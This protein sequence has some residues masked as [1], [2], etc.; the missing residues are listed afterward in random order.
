MAANDD[1]KLSLRVEFESAK[2][3][4]SLK[5]LE[6]AFDSTL[7]RLGKSD[8]EIG[9]L[10]AIARDVEAGKTKLAELPAEQQR[11]VRAMQETAR[12]V[13][14]L[15]ELGIARSHKQIRAEIDGLRASYEQLKRTGVLTSAEL[16]QAKGRLND[17][18]RELR[19][20]MNSSRTV[21]ERLGG[22]FGN[23]GALIAGGALARGLA[24]VSRLADSLSQLEGRLRL[25]EG[26]QQAANERLAQLAAVANRAR[27]P[28]A[29]VA[30]AYAKMAGSIRAAGG[31]TQQAVEFNEA[32]AL[33]LKTSGASAQEAGAVMRQL[34]QALQRGRLQGDE[35]V[36]VAENG[37][38]VL[39]Y[40]AA[41]LGVS[42]GRLTEMAQ[43]GELTTDKLLRLTGSLGQIRQDAAQLPTTVG[44]AIVRVQNAF[45]A[46][47]QSSALVRGAVQTLATALTA[48]AAN[49]DV[50]A[51]ATLALGTAFLAVKLP[52]MVAAVT[53]LGAAIAALN[54]VT[55]ALA[56]AATAAVG[57]IGLL[58]GALGGG[59]SDAVQLAQG[60][61]QVKASLGQLAGPVATVMQSLS[62]EVASASQTATQVATRLLEGSA[63][64]AQRFVGEAREQVA[65]IERDAEAARAVIE[66]RY[67]N[68]TAKSQALAAL[69]RTT[70]EQ[71]LA[72]VES[73]QL[74]ALAAVESAY[75]KVREQ[76]G[77]T[78]LDI[79]KIEGET[80]KK[81]AEIWSGLA[82][83]YAGAIARM[84][85][86]NGRL[87]QDI[88]RLEQA[89]VRFNAEAEAGILEERRRSM[90]A[91]AAYADRVR[92]IDAKL[93]EARQAA[94]DGDAKKAEAI[95]RE[96]IRL[97]RSINQ[98]VESEIDGVRT[99][100]ISAAD[101]QARAIR[102]IE[103]A[104]S[105]VNDAFA[106]GKNRAAEQIKENEAAIR[107][108]EERLREARTQA[109]QLRAE[110]EAEFKSRIELDT[111]TFDAAVER[112]N[113]GLEALKSGASVQLKLDEAQAAL[114][115]FKTDPNNTL[116][117]V[118]AA[119]ALDQAG[120]ALA[121]LRR[122]AEKERVP[123]PAGLDLAQAYQDFESLRR[124]LR[125]AETKSRHKVDAKTSVDLARAE[126]LGLNGTDTQS[127]HTITVRRV[128]ANAAG[129]LVGRALAATQT[130]GAAV[131]HFAHGGPV[132]ARM[133][134][135]W[136]PGT[137]N[138]DTVPR[139]LD[140]G[141]FVLRR[142]AVA[143]YRGLLGAVARFAMGG[144]VRSPFVRP[145]PGLPAQGSGG[146]RRLPQRALPEAWTRR[147]EGRRF[148][149][150]DTSGADT[151]G[152]IEGMI[153]AARRAPPAQ[154][155]GRLE[156]A[157]RLAV[158][159]MIERLRALRR[160]G[161]AV[162][163]SAE[164]DSERDA[165]ER[166][167]SRRLADD[168]E[169]AISGI[170][171]TAAVGKRFARGG[172]VPGPTDTVPALLTPGE[173]VV[174]RRT[175]ERLGVGFFESLNA[176]ALPARGLARA[177]AAGVQGFAQGGLV[178]GVVRP[179]ERPYLVPGPLA[180]PASPAVTNAL[181]IHAGGLS[182]PRALARLLLP[183]L[184]ALMRRR[185]A[186]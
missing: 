66:R 46:W 112:V 162:D 102:K 115:A 165:V 158:A 88:A 22:A 134:G 98:A 156:A 97:S 59:A 30:D 114:D 3:E 70:E 17:R 16:A 39:D 103:A 168:F 171:A 93:S 136:V 142:A 43:A 41:S 124:T 125:E 33:A 56:A 9:A 106:E 183:E 132:F 145:G 167:N 6:A 101:A 173:Y 85:S 18:L 62:Q 45:T 110:L 121:E 141:A 48:V 161:V 105:I 111:T 73:A 60:I 52:A 49:M 164:Y 87:E 127:T 94:L 175:V 76:A 34:G 99:T 185:A 184:E 182:D 86:D 42:R 118:K 65:A 8:A 147:G 12:G 26:S 144:R 83:A 7:R 89:R 2:A 20:S 166:F 5:R 131:R 38:R 157:L 63:Q 90:G 152:G 4:T 126:I 14:L 53:G 96:V 176:L 169:G 36:S 69:V 108:L 54:P 74:K 25:V 27:V 77:A 24:S 13:R 15:D 95:G 174:P 154:R 181:T 160:A 79:E 113:R 84:L 138:A 109:E 72:A 137:G 122:R 178:P 100:V 61:E 75:A 78:A 155:W 23:L 130:V 104:Q 58:R 148:F 170:L 92:E 51:G 50:V 150:V 180:Q 151:A 32:L 179:P 135:G 28:V 68:E 44:D 29:D 163:P 128:E 67:D 143:R 123:I 55:L 37:G 80:A 177:L 64:A 11:I 81:R 91:V 47:V 119:L 21:A 133:R 129:G 117:E 107:P 153:E 159:M 1:L 116:L 10:K 31:S 71:K 186:A 40:L 149:A 140:A 139:A 146:E 172:R 35:F 120:D 82:D 19:E 57:A